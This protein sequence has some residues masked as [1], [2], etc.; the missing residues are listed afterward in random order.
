MPHITYKNDVVWQNF[1]RTR[2]QMGPNGP[3]MLLRSLASVCASDATQPSGLERFAATGAVLFGH[4]RTLDVPAGAPRFA[5]GT[6][7]QGW[8]FAPLIGTPVAQLDALGLA[9]VAMLA[10]DE[11]EPGCRVRADHVALASG[12]TTM[13]TVALWA[14]QNNRAI[15]SSGTYLYPSIAGG[16]ATSSHGSRLGFGGIQNMVLGMHLL[17]GS[18]E[19][20]WIE[21]A[22]AP[23]LS[24]VGLARLA[25][26]GTPPR[27]VRDDD[28]FED[29]L[30]HL[31]AMGIVNGVALELVGKQKFALMQRITLL[32]PDFLQDIAAGRF[33]QI[34]ARLNCAA[35][36]AF[37]ELTINPHAPFDYP[38]T[39][40]LYFP[41]SRK[42]LLP[43]GP[44]EILHPADAILRL[45]A[46]MVP[47]ETGL[48]IQDLLPEAVAAGATQPIPQWVLPML[49][50]DDSIFGYYRG[51][52]SYDTPDTAFDPDGD[53]PAGSK[54]YLW[55]EL[56]KG[57]ITG[58]QPGALYNASFAIPLE[59][60]D[61]AVPLICAA[62]QDLAPSFVFTLRFVDKAAGTLAFTR[63]ER[64]AVIEIDGLSPLI[65]LATKARINQ[66]LQYAPALSAALDVLAVTLPTGAA[67][68]RGALDGAGIRYSMHWAKLGDLD[69]AKVHADYGHPR[70]PESLIYRWRQTRD[71]LL[72]PFGKRIFWNDALIRYGLLDP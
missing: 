46:L 38:A 60:V 44:A 17:V 34:A 31:G 48:T 39:N 36:P 54:P 56:H 32:T 50:G 27:L 8:S 71:D 3:E 10:D 64:N 68:V 66:A 65:C 30:V 62:V 52:K 24:K 23:V 53:A 9:S 15:H 29:A 43:S 47:Y 33:E 2:G 58:G 14:E 5:A 16:A 55:S 41:T 21:P 13:E 72:T 28:R 4:L 22:S 63:F 26:D 25:I 1:H 45:G 42:S 59:Q 35:A 69:Q 70:D 51:L 49:I 57:T 40:I 19:H 6:V 37:Y 11:R 67:R 7:G 12:G 18:G 20:V 61:K